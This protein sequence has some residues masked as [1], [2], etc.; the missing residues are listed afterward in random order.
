MNKRTGVTQRKRPDNYNEKRV[1]MR[2]FEYLT[3]QDGTEITTTFDENGQRLYMDWDEQAGAPK[4]TKH[5][6][7]CRDAMLR[8]RFLAAH[9]R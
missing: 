4:K 6:G 8:F 9:T 5:V 1:E 2:N 7:T 3:L